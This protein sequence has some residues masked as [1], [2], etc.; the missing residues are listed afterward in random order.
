MYAILV[1]NG[2]LVEDDFPKGLDELEFVSQLG[3]STGAQKVRD[4]AGLFY[5]KKNGNPERLL[6][7]YATNQAYRALGVRV[8]E[9]SLYTAVKG[10]RIEAPI[11]KSERIEAR[12]NGE[13]SLVLLSR[14]VPETAVD[15]GK[16][17]ENLGL[18]IHGA[19]LSPEWKKNRVASIKAVQDAVKKNFVAD[20]LLA[21]WDVAGLDFDNIQYDPATGEVWRIDNGAGLDFRAQGARKSPHLFSSVIQEFETLRNP[22][23]NVNSSFLFETATDEEIIE[24][25]EAILPRKAAF[26]AA[27]PDPL[28]DIMEQR[29]DYLQVYKNQLSNRLIAPKN[30][31]F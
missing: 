9:L 25:I 4:R 22:K 11:I 5:A 24:Q 21:N 14:F 16:F 3:G 15:L 7:E 29:F 31:F 8:P 26:L 17:L 30:S 13:K 10:E 12:A 2:V 28:K 6:T 23:I 20:C 1:K 18:N 27:I 19:I